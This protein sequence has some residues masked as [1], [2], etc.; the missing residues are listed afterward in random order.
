[1][2]PDTSH[3]GVSEDTLCPGSSTAPG[4]VPNDDL[5]HTEVVLSWDFVKNYVFT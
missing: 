5:I 3:S 1:M 4:S 2:F